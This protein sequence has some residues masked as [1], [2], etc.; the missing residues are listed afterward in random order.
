MNLLSEVASPNV[1]HNIRD[2]FACMVEPVGYRCEFHNGVYVLDTEDPMIHYA[3]DNAFSDAFAQ[4]QRHL[5]P[6]NTSGLKD[7]SE[8][9][10]SHRF[11]CMN[12]HLARF[13]TKAV[14][15]SGFLGI[16]AGIP[17]F[18]QV[19]QYMRVM[20][21]TA[22]GQH[23]PH[24]DSDYAVDE[25]MN[26]RMSLV[27]YGNNCHSGEIAFVHHDGDYRDDWNRQANDEEI[28]LKIQPRVGRIVIFDHS[29]CHTVLPFT[30]SGERRIVRGDLIFKE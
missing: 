22:G 6:V 16:H 9:V 4:Y 28:Y 10:G 23:F 29:L 27:A 8:G 11:C 3:Y 2:V 24:Y 17:K 26:T 14:Q 18:V 12:E 7:V 30:D 15:Q 20:K 13:F 21:Y 5:Y 1:T 25:T 19:S